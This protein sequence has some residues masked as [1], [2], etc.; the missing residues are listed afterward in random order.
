M[1]NKIIEILESRKNVSYKVGQDP[2][3][4]DSE[5]FELIADEI[6]KLF[7]IPVVINRV[8]TIIAAAVCA[9]IAFAGFIGILAFIHG[10]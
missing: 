10:L 9:A 2:Q 5:N 8:F 6:V 7:A 1:K 3:S 4:I